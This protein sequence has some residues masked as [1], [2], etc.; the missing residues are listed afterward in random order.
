MKNDS[1]NFSTFLGIDVGK[2]EL[3]ACL[4]KDHSIVS[5]QIFLNTSSGL[6]EML[7]WVLDFEVSLD[8]LLVCLEHTGVYAQRVCYVMYGSGATVWQVSARRLQ[9]VQLEPDRLKNDQVDARKIASFAARFHDQVQPYS[10]DSEE[11]GKL[12]DYARIRKQLVGDKQRILNQISS[13]Q[14]Q[15]IQQTEVIQIYRQ[16]LEH[17]KAQIKAVEKLI[18]QLIS[19]CQ[20]LKRYDQI[21]RSIPGIG[22]VTSVKILTVTKG[23]TRML[24]HKKLAA[25]GGTAPYE[26]SSGTSLNRKRRI[27][28]KA[29][30]E[31]KALLTTA[32]MAAIRRGAVFHDYYNE[33]LQ[34]PARLPMQ[35]INII[36]NKLL[37]IAVTLIKKDELFDK[38]TF[39]SQ[40][41]FSKNSLELS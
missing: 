14:L 22:P 36:R 7:Q 4:L 23:F 32:V 2:T 13:Y 30:K 28:R 24:N 35:A 41:N 19:S 29:D 20:K 25:F 9:S 40:L 8:N 34:K 39:L 5:E 18:R 37:K 38:N 17:T 26:R 33:L 3:A 12:K 16:R 27:S 21:L 1:V 10:A 11:I 31:M 15:M 6:G